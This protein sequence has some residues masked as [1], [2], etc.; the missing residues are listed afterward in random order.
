MP[1]TPLGKLEGLA[2]HAPLRA[3]CARGKAQC[4]EVTPKLAACRLV[5]QTREARNLRRGEAGRDDWPPVE[6]DA[7]RC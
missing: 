5:E 7:R 1:V 4:F 2:E 3:F 6:D